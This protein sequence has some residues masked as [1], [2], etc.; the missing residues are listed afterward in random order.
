[1]I[2]MDNIGEHLDNSSTTNLTKIMKEHKK[3]FKAVLTGLN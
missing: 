1:M 3:I 2:E